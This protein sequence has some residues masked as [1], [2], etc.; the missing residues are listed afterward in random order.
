MEPWQPI[1]TVLL[2]IFLVIA[3]ETL[4]GRKGR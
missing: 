3:A 4:L 1:L 2:V